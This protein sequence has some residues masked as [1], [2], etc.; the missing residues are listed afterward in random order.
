ML[1][2]YAPIDERSDLASLP[3]PNLARLRE[4]HPY[5]KGTYIL[6]HTDGTH[7]TSSITY[8]AGIK[9]LIQG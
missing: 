5:G 8:R 4:V 6:V 9:A 2:S 7:L 1:R 3:A